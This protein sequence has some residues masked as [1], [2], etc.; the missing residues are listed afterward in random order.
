MHQNPVNGW[1]AIQLFDPRKQFRLRRYGRQLE[2]H[3][4]QTEFATHLVFRANVGARRQIIA[5][6]N[7]G[8]ARYNSFRF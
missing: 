6:E 7:H 5:H 1:I 4:M 8:Q 2:L 3:G